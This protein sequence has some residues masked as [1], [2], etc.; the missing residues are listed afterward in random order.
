MFGMLAMIR[1]MAQLYNE[2]TF[3][4][5]NTFTKTKIHFLHA[6]G[7]WFIVTRTSGTLSPTPTPGIYIMTKEQRVKVPV[8]FS[9]KDITLHPFMIKHCCW[10]LHRWLV[11]KL[12]QCS[13]ILNENTRSIYGH[14]RTRSGNI[15]NPIIIRLNEGE[16]ASIVS[17]YGS[18]SLPNSPLHD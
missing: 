14:P 12:Y 10:T 2:A 17:D 4:T 13:R 3:N 18:M 7:L 1:T 9:E 16:H 15:I 6:Q 8:S 11:K 5:F